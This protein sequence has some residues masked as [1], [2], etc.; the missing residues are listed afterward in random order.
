[1]NEAMQ[2][3]LRAVGVEVSFE[4]I[5]WSTM[6]QRRGQGA[7]MP[8]QAGISGLEQFLVLGRPRLRLPQH[9]RQRE[10]PAARQQSGNTRVPEID[11]LC[12]AVRAEFDPEKQ[13]TLLAELHA[14]MVEDADL[15]VCGAR[16]EPAGR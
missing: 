4:V 10:D 6:T 7:Q 12:A 16:H 14:R 2:E 9:A 3:M 13:D 8:D 11:R 1:M 15:A 5:D